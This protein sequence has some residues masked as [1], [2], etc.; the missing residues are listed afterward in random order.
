MSKRPTF[1]EVIRKLEDHINED[2]DFSAPEV[3]VVHE[4]VFAW[5]AVKWLIVGVAAAVSAAAVLVSLF[6][7]VRD[8]KWPGG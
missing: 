7:S 6:N 4:I 8:F 1:D 3:K 5:R 2:P